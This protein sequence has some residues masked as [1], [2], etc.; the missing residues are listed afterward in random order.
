MEL[1]TVV[2][3]SVPKLSADLKQQQWAGGGGNGKLNEKV[4]GPI[5]TMVYVCTEE[6]I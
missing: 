6:D 4:T 5:L 1:I 3:L 2:I